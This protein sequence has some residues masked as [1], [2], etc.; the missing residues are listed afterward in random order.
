[1]PMTTSHGWHRLHPGLAVTISI[2]LA[3]AAAHNCV[4]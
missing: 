3:D 1:M 4:R 2:G